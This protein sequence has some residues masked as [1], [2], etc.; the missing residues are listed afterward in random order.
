MALPTQELERL[1]VQFERRL[2][3]ELGS[4]QHGELS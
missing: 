3:A 4:P 2:S 1:A